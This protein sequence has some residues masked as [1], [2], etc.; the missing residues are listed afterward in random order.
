M[1]PR[2]CAQCGCTDRTP[3]TVNVLDGDGLPAMTRPCAWSTSAQLLV[4]AAARAELVRDVD[5]DLC[6]GCGSA[7]VVPVKRQVLL[8][9]DEESYQLL[10]VLKQS[11]ALVGTVARGVVDVLQHLVASAADGVRRPGAWE[12]GW[13]E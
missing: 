4:I 5:A 3:C 10:R 9:L 8:E 13:I 7:G 12:R 6:D 11:P 2:T 1:K